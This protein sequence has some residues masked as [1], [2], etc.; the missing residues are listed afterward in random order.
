MIAAFT[1]ALLL[2]APDASPWH[3]H[4]SCDGGGWWRRRIRIDVRNDGSRPAEGEPVGIPIGR[5]PGAADLA[6][7]RAESVRVCDA[8]GAE[9]LLRID[10]PD[11]ERIPKGPVP[12]GSILT[13]PAECPPGRTASSFVYFDNPSAWQVPDV[14]EVAAGLRNGGLERGS[15]DAPAGW[16]HDAPDEAHRA[17]WVDEHPHGGRRCLKTIVAPLA[18]PTWIATR[19]SGIP[20]IGGARYVLRAWVK[21]RDVAGY[22]GWYIHLGDEKNSM[23]AAPMLNAGGGTYDW[24]EVSLS[25]AAP[26]EARIA[27]VGTVLR[28]TGTA[29]FDDVSLACESP[30]V[31][32][33]SASPPEAL[34]LRE[35]GA[36]ARWPV[37]FARRDA[38]RIPIRVLNA[39]DEPIDGPLACVD[40]APIAGRLRGGL[41]RGGLQA[42][43][44][45]DPISCTRVADTLLLG[46]RVPPR[47]ALTAHA[48]LVEGERAETDERDAYARLIGSPRNLVRNASFEDGADLPAVWT[49]GAPGERS[50][51]VRMDLGPGLFGARAAR[52]RVPGDA[53]LVWTG[54][55]QR[56]P[57]RAG[58]TYI[59][60]AYLRCEDVRDGSV[61]LH[62]HYLNAEGGLCRTAQFA[63]AGPALSGTRDW[64]LLAGRFSMPPDIATFELHLTMLARGTVLHDGV[65][66]AEVEEATAGSPERRSRAAP[67]ALAVWPVNAIVKVFRDDVPPAEIALARIAAAR[68]EREALQLAVRSAEARRGIRVQVTPPARAAAG[69]LRDIDVGVIGYVPIDCPSNYYRT[70]VPAYRRKIPSGSAGSDGWSGLWPDPIL[71]RDAFDLAANKT[72]PIWITVRVPEDAAAGEYAGEVRLAADGRALATVPFAVR[73]RDFSLPAER[74]IGAIYDV[75]LRGIW[76]LPG[77]TAAETRDAFWRFLAERRLCAD[78][79]QPDPVLRYEGGRVVSD[80]AAYD[81]AARVYFDECRF[82]FTYTP[83]VFYLFGWGHPPAVKFGEAPYEGEHPYEGADR[84]VLRPAYKRAYQACLRAYWDHM[85]QK[86]RADRCVLYI[87]DEPFYDRPEIRAQMKAL[88]AMIHEVDPAIPIYSSTWLHRPEWDG[89]LDVWGIGHYG[90]V[91]VETMRA[92][93][94]AGDRIW[95]TT[96]GQMCTDT[97]YCAIE[98]LLPHYCFHAGAEAYEFWGCTWLTYDPYAFGWH[99]FIHQSSSPGESTWVRY[100]NGDGYLAYPGST[101]GYDG[102][103]SSIRLEQ[104]GEGVDDAEYLLI[105]R[106]RIARAR[107]AGEDPR[108]A[109]EVL[110]RGAALVPIPNAGGRHSTRILPDPDAVLRIREE[111]AEAIERLGRR[112]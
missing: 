73:V 13:I 48:Y 58:A 93:R 91:P 39:G 11:G 38:A 108:R 69:S 41:D 84:G 21:A 74:R 32:R 1:L 107:E 72:Q 57:V 12:P 26:P 46:I 15:G 77:R 6:G 98:R 111:A 97:P 24:K 86:G 10:G 29:W 7:A 81:R 45:A 20:I 35:A 85:R 18:E 34:A 83:H 55:R 27:S 75:R 51:G 2:G 70:D 42:F 16:R 36:D 54:W 37:G 14:F 76:D 17:L 31:L 106:E 65:L 28:G 102:F 40:L 33:A 104:A 100:P 95:F 109:E 47:T 78:R 53:P 110:A 80:F 64:T 63:G 23:M 96:D 66:L 5:E 92:L 67:P 88:C 19:Q 3:L 49:G 60:A 94:D 43:A 25:F 9:M 50:G 79:I 44:G 59:F 8:R 101:I 90:N 89:A 62:A 4:L 30:R 68:N 61:Q 82:P 52:I 71:P 103:V 56:V 105:L 112:S 87:S 99:A 22:A